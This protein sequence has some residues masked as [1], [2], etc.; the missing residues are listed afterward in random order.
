[1]TAWL[2]KKTI[3]AQFGMF[4]CVITNK[5]I[6]LEHNYIKL[7]Q[8]LE[9]YFN[10]ILIK[11]EDVNFP[12]PDITFAHYCILSVYGLGKVASLIL[13]EAEICRAT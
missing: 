9:Q 13:I 11:G 6:D 4:H 12:R 2:A 1:M 5:T 8:N 7:S 10:N 3:S